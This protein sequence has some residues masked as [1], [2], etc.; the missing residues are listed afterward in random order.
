[1][2]DDASTWNLTFSFD[3]YGPSVMGDFG[4]DG[5]LDVLTRNSQD[6]GSYF[7]NGQG[8]FTENPGNG[9]ELG[10][11][12][13]VGDINQDGKD[14]ILDPRQNTLYLYLAQ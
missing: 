10:F 3:A 12:T 7:G 13:W 8:A 14:D 5:F 9:I 2:S 6:L 11:E 4:G 1:M